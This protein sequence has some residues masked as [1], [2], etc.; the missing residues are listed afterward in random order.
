MGMQHPPQEHDICTAVSGIDSEGILGL[1][2]VQGMFV[3][4]KLLT[5][6]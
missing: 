1:Q 2:Q 4:E 5:S 6:I 3:K